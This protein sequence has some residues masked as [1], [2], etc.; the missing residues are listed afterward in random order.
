MEY[1]Q[2]G[3]RYQLN[4]Q[5][6]RL[7]HASFTLMSNEQFLQALPAALHLATF[8]CW[9]KELP[10]SQVLADD[11]IIH[12]LVHLLHIPDEP[13]IDLAEIRKAFNEQLALAP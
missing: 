7:Q 4:Y 10:A 8:L 5:E 6:L 2:N 11:G 13:L 9:F 3:K 12:Q 1:V